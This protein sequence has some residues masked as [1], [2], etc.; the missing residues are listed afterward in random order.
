MCDRYVYDITAFFVME[1]QYSEAKARKLI[2]LFRKV[3]P[4]PRVAFLVD[5]SA[6]ISIQRKRDIPSIDQHEKLRSLYFDLIK[7]DH[8]IT[9]LDG[10]KELDDLN[11][12]VWTQVHHR[13]KN[14]P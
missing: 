2:K 13:L 8:K 11:D 4:Q 3:A 6:E 9:V 14:K 5:V 10:S 1:L 7:G 12:I